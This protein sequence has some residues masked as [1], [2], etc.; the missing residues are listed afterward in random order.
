MRT[1]SRFTGPLEAD[2]KSKPQKAPGGTEGQS[3]LPHAVHAAQYGQP[4]QDQ[5]E[6]WK[7]NKT[8]PFEDTKWE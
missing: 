4:L 7:R 6:R 3:A 2:V 1:E 8:R 5:S